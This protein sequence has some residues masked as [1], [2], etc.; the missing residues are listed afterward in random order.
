MR[1]P[2]LKP[3]PDLDRAARAPQPDDTS[4]ALLHARTQA[5]RRLL[6]ALVLLA[7]AVAGFPL[8]FETQPRPL[9][10]TSNAAGP[11][12]VVKGVSTQRSVD[13][14]AVSADPSAAETAS[15]DVPARAAS[16][17]VAP[18]AA[19]PA[20]PRASTPKQ[21]VEAPSVVAAA[22]APA[23]EDAAVATAGRPAS[24]PAAP[25]AVAP[26]LVS[27]PA[28]PDAV[29]ES[30]GGSG[31]QPLRD[32]AKEDRTQDTAKIGTKEPVKEG[33]RE[34]VKQP[35]NDRPGGAVERWVV[36]VGAYTDMERMRQTRQ[37]VEKLGFK[38]YI[39][40]VDT[41]TGKRTRLRL[42]PFATKKE[43]EEAALRLKAAGMAANMLSV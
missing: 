27:R 17:D 28:I 18:S 5:R 2:F 33:E 11:A 7:V 36:Q 30:A 29:K 13:T 6:G 10:G 8:L 42:G 39:T 26:P 15:A 16:V 40:D 24:R 43:A 32:P 1:L 23:V 4:G 3:K 34:T 21:L 19:V 37:K 12:L 14:V 31:K 35:T 9:P 38:T 41:P 20:D 22:A 25:L